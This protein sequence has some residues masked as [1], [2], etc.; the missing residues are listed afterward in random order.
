MNLFLNEIAMNAVRS[1]FFLAIAVFLFD[2]ASVAKHIF[3]AILLNVSA[4]LCVLVF[5]AG[6]A[7]TIKDFNSWRASKEKQ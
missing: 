5:C 6:V 2:A 3:P 7:V 4:C 1:V